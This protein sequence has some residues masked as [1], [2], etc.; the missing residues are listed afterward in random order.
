MFANCLLQWRMVIQKRPSHLDMQ[1]HYL[2]QLEGCNYLLSLRP[3]RGACARDVPPQ[4]ISHWRSYIVIQSC[5]NQCVNQ[6]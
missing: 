5:F 4:E 3:P 6:R 1:S 2:T